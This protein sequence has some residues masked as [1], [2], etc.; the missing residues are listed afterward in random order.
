MTAHDLKPCPFCGG[1]AEFVRPAS[2][3]APYVMCATNYCTQP[4]QDSIAKWNTR[5]A[6]A[7]PFKRGAPMKEPS[8]E[9]RLNLPDDTFN[10]IGA[11]ES[12]CNM[13]RIE[14]DSYA[15]TLG[16][17]QALA[18]QG[19][20][21]GIEGQRYVS[22][23]LMQAAIAAAMVGA[24]KPL[25]W[26]YGKAECELGTYV[27]ESA[28]YVDG[29]CAAWALNRG[30]TDPFFMDTN[31]EPAENKEA[32]KAAAE[33]DY[34]ARI[35]SALSIPTDATAALEAVKAQARNEALEEAAAKIIDQYDCSTGE[36]MADAIRAM[37]GEQ[38]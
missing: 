31:G 28:E 27:I 13:L 21:I 10:Y 25:K 6:R 16:Q 34:Q 36:K 23:A 14:V 9:E 37:K 30:D 26:E 1:E 22:E 29:R 24:V 33:A 38:Q 12:E 15:E 7:I 2:G 8:G 11:L 20:P 19:L 35:L 3:G 18:T 17:I 4:H 5:S 32:A